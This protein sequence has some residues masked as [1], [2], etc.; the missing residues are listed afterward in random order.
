MK[1]EMKLAL[2]KIIVVAMCVF[3]LGYILLHVD[4]IIYDWGVV[5]TVWGILIPAIVIRY[6][7]DNSSVEEDF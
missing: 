6:I 2:I 5:K 3:E 1:I 4:S 7:F